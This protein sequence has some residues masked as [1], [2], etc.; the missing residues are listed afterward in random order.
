MEL[1][2]FF[3]SSLILFLHF[4]MLVFL[5]YAV[6]MTSTFSSYQIHKDDLK[7]YSIN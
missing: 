6:Y 7:G 2:E 3:L 5:F 4:V 1:N